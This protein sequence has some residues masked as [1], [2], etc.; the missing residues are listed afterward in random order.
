M[1]SCALRLRPLRAVPAQER[2]CL[3]PAE[4]AGA[5]QRILI[6]ED[7]RILAKNMKAYLSR[8][9]S[10]VRI[11]ADAGESYAALESFSPDALFL[12]YRLPDVDGLMA[13][14]EIVRRLAR[15]IDCVLISGNPTEQLVRKARA[16]G[17]HR[18]LCKPFRVAELQRQLDTLAPACANDGSGANAQ[19]C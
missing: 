14:A 7:E 6:V 15:R 10:E 1:K 16:A 13:Y 8:R 17:I 5:P 4:N 19:R 2:A 9:A 12:D 18:I 11:A 3:H